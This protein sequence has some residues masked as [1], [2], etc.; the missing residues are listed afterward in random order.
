MLSRWMLILPTHTRKA[1]SSLLLQILPTVFFQ[2]E[3]IRYQGY[4]A[5]VHEVYTS[6]GYILTMQR[7]PHGKN[8]T[9]SN[10][11]HPILLQHGLTATASNWIVNLPDQSL[12]EC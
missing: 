10:D 2:D 8:Q 11:R 3:I 12:G 5:E 7:I 1:S 9:A 6:D 4:A